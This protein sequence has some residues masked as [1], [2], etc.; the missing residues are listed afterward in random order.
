M[1][2]SVNIT[3][4]H[5]AKMTIHWSKLSDSKII[6]T[7]HKP[8]NLKLYKLQSHSQAYHQFDLIPSHN[9]NATVF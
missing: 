6:K 3:S 4:S 9:Y 5:F 8:K 7:A 1:R 2:W